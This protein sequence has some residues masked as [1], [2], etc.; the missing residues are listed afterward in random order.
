MRSFPTV[1]CVLG[2]L[3]VFWLNAASAHHG[4]TGRYD[5]GRPVYLKGRVVEARFAP[6]HPQLRLA[7][8][9]G[10]VPALSAA[11][12][13]DFLGEVI[14]RPGDIGQV[15]TI[16]FA[17]INMYFAMGDRLAVGDRVEVIAMVNCEPPHELRS[18]WLRLVDGTLLMRTGGNHRK[19]SSC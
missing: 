14:V 9:A 2:S 11:E 3:A 17:P 8:E 18:Q 19:V 13:A 6:P 12:T 15:R 4:G 16:E 7:V 5:A 10:Q 1:L